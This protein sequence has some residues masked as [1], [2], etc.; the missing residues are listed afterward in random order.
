MQI[1]TRPLI[2]SN[3]LPGASYQ[4]ISI[5]LPYY[6]QFAAFLRCIAAYYNRVDAR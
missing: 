6:N 4:I 3:F 1:N 5:A 2:K